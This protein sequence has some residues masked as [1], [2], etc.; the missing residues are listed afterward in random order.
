MVKRF[1]NSLNLRRWGSLRWFN[2][3]YTLDPARKYRIWF[4]GLPPEIDIN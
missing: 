1:V 2:T 3:Q 4:F